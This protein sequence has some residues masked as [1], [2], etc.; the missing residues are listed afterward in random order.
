MTINL[1]Y[2]PELSTSAGTA[3]ITPGDAEQQKT[4][5][6]SFA[7]KAV[8]SLI[9]SLPWLQANVYAA[10]MTRCLQVAD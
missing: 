4:T 3:L 5:K 10:S 2:K 7:W 8:F 1:P 6:G 9:F